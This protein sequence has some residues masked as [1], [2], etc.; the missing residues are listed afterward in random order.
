MPNADDVLWFK[1]QFHR[2]IEEAVTGTPFDVDM[3]A[4]LACQETGEIWPQLRRKGLSRKQVLALC[5]GDTIDAKGD[6][7]RRAFPRTKSDLLAVTDGQR[8]FD[9]ARK[10][11]VDMA[12][13]MTAYE[14]VATNPNKFCHGFGIFQL[15]LQFFLSDPDYFMERRYEAF[16]PCL[17]KCLGELQRALKRVGWADR[18]ALTDLEM[19]CIAI[20]Y[21]TGRYKPGLGLKQGYF[22][23]TH[24]YGEAFFDYLRLART[25]ALPGATPAI[26]A[27]P[28]GSAAVAPPSPVTATGPAYRVE[29]LQTT[30]RLRSEAIVSTPDPRANVIGELPD[31]HLV[32]AVTGKAVHGFL[33]VETSLGGA[34]LHGFASTKYL[35]LQPGAAVIA[36]TAPAPKP[37]TTGIVA[38]SMP[39]KPGVITK[40]SQKADAHSLNEAG[41]PGRNGTSPEQLRAELA[42]IVAW[43][44]VEKAAHLRYRPGTGSTFCNIYAHDYCHLAGVYLPRVWWTSKAIEALATGKVVTPRYANTIEEVRANGLFRWLRDF[45]PRF[46]WRQTGTATKLQQEVNQGAI[47]LVVAR[48]TVEGL[49][50]HITV[51]VPETGDLTARRDGKGEVVAPLQSQAGTVNFRYGNGKTGWWRS[52]RFAESGFWLHG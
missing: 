27:P 46:G 16:S 25:A 41:Q 43:L 15:D 36:V 20:A 31:G 49:P 19:A 45:G 17:A 10:A 34:H 22:D 21:N 5:V 40:R 11:L 39:R 32:R 7:G 23:G 42:A 24:Y 51:V 12:A 38:V 2:E 33:E 9:I 18:A 1:R 4:A 50:G 6:G 35:V 44:D 28:P 3:L 47:G 13:H 52:E 8:M 14:A 29:T 48:R 30:L 26:P 37:P